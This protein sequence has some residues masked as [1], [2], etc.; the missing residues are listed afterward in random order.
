MLK[1][2]EVRII[3]R[4]IYLLITS[5]CIVWLLIKGLEIY[6]I[7]PFF[8]LLYQTYDFYLFNK[9]AY[10]EISTYVESVHY[11]D[12]VRV[13]SLFLLLVLK[14]LENHHWISDFI[15]CHFLI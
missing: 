3:F 10:D 11:R 5:F 12:F 2:F 14:H 1:R 7:I 4:V 15:K 8:V 13:K 6:A 9:K